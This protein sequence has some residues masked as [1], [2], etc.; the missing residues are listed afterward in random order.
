MLAHFLFGFE[1]VLAT[2][3]WG[4]LVVGWYARRRTTR[5]FVAAILASL[6]LLVPWGAALVIIAYFYL[7][8]PWHGQFQ[9]PML[10]FVT[11][12]LLGL[13]AIWICAWRQNPRTQ[14]PRAATWPLARIAIFALVVT[15]LAQ[16]THWM[17]D[18]L[19]RERLADARREAQ[20]LAQSVMPRPLFDSENAATIYAQVIDAMGDKFVVPPPADAEEARRQEESRPKLDAAP[21]QPGVHDFRTWFWLDLWDHLNSDDYDMRSPRLA[22]FLERHRG[23]RELLLAATS[24]PGCNFDRDYS[25]P[26]IDM[27]LSE[28]QS[29]RTAAVYLA[30]D[31]RQA[32]AVGDDARAV[33]DL[34]ALNRLAEHIAQEPWTVTIL[35]AYGHEGTAQD[36]LRTILGE[37]AQPSQE[38]LNLKIRARQPMLDD[39]ERALRI[40]EATGLFTI[41]S[42]DQKLAGAPIAP[43]A[44]L[45]RTYYLDAAIEDSHDHFNRLRDLRYR[46]NY[47]TAATMVEVSQLDDSRR[48]ESANA[49]A[50]AI[51]GAWRPVFSMAL[52]MEA[53]RRLTHIAQGLYRY[54]HAQGED[55]NPRREFPESLDALVPEYLDYL[56]SDPFHE[57]RPMQYRR[58]DRGAVVYSLGPNFKDDGG[59][60]YDGV[61]EQGDEIFECLAPPAPTTTEPAAEEPLGAPSN[62]ATE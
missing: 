34:T 3:L 24:I 11:A 37:T 4:A 57:G 38:L 47:P 45:L 6:L 62:E 43:V 29:S 61:N 27:L 41:A 46:L 23:V 59:M 5:V 60:P 16:T 26:S 14:L 52:R 53:K 7:R 9:S 55:L 28:V 13:V 33:E 20:A 39:V 21:E 10:I 30:I 19:A 1:C 49:L 54:Y 18:G 44:S 42:L 48:S 58:T 8:D 51:S 35:V 15:M 22:A 50:A 36:T 32:A 31:A 17:L 25:R 56:P 12:V 40:A 2:L